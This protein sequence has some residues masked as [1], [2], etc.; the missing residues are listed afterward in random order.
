MSE[1]K[2][3]ALTSARRRRGV[4]KGSITRLEDRV[5][6]YETKEEITHVDCLAIKRLIKKFES[7]DD[8]FRK[9]HY[10]IVELLEDEAVDEEQA[11]LDDHD[12]RITDLVER[13]Q[14]LIIIPEPEVDSPTSAITDASKPLQVQLGRIEK[15]IG[16]V[17]ETMTSLIRGPKIDQCLLRQLEEEI[18]SLRAELTE[19][20][21][22]IT[23]LETGGKEL[24]EFEAALNKNLFDLGLRIKR[25]LSDAAS[26]KE[27][28]KV[29]SGVKL[30]KIE[31]P[32]F[33]GNI[34]NWGH[35]WEQFTATVHAKE[36]LSDVDKLAYLQHA[37]K[38]GTAKYTIEGLAQSSGSYKEA[39]DCLQ[40]RYDRPR[41]IH[42]AHVRAI[43]DA[44]P[45]KDGHGREL[46]RMHDV[47]NQHL[48]A[49]KTMDYDPSGPFIT[50][51]LELK[52]D[53]STMFEWQRHSQDSRDVPHYQRL[54]EFLDLRA[55]ASESNPNTTRGGKPQQKN[56]YIANAGE[57]CIACEAGK[58]P[59]YTCGTFRTMD[60][61][62]KL[63]LLKENGHCLN[64]LKPG[65]FLRQCPT[66]Q[67]CRK[68][69]KPHHT[70]LHIEKDAGA[71]KVKGPTTTKAISSHASHLET[72]HQQVLLMTCRVKIVA[73]GGY[74]TQA[75]ALLDSASSTSFITERLA[76]HLGLRR[77]RHSL[78]ISG[79]GGI[80]ARSAARGIVSFEITNSQ[81]TCKVIP[82]EAIV[83]QRITTDIPTQPI[84]RDRGWKHLNGLHLADPDFGK[85]GRIDL[86]LGADVFGKS[87]RHGRRYGPAGTPT[88]LSTQFG[89]VITGG[90]RTKCPSGKVSTFCASALSGDDLLKRFWEVEG[91]TFPNPTFSTEERNVMEHFKRN[92]S[93]DETGRFVVPLPRRPD[94]T[95]LGES[96]LI[97]VKRFIAVERSLESS[98]RSRDFANAVWEYFDMDHAEPVPTRDMAKPL[99]E[100]YYMPMHTVI[101]TSSVTSQMR[102]VFDA[103]AKTAS[104]TSLN[105]HLIV[106]PTVHASLV[107]VLL[108]FRRHKIALVADISKMYRAV[109]LPEN[110]RDLH[111]FVWRN[112]PRDP[113]VD[114]RMKRLTF[115]VSASSF[116]AN[117]AVKQNAIDHAEKYPQASRAVLESFYVDDGLTGADTLADAVELQGQLQCLFDIAGFTLRKWKSNLPAVLKQ[118]PPDLRDQ[119]PC[120]EIGEVSEFTKVLGVE[121]D[122]E[123]D[124][125]RPLITTNLIAC[126]RLTKRTLVSDIAR[127]FDVLGWCSPSIIKLKIL[128]QRIWEEK[129]EWDEE[130]P[131]NVSGI[132]ERWRNELPLLRNHLIPRCYFQETTFASRQLHGFCDAS[133]SAYAAVVYLRMTDLKGDAKVAIVIGKTKVAPI[134][135]LTI[136]RLELCGALILARILKHAADILNVPMIDVH[137]WT[138]STVVL[139]WLRG[140]PRRFKS[141]VG[142]RV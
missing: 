4:V 103:S 13:L 88:A 80:E 85:P 73:P 61:D 40:K 110:Q 81:G 48:R 119:Q 86:L 33:D 98:G 142:N 129:L 104:G 84:P 108:R 47:V 75:R 121:W 94:V 32:T 12:E 127:V 15:R 109:L 54:L 66:D 93:R 42:Q 23:L 133:E 55:Q 118:V 77:T 18:L 44:A 100:V 70:W 123:S 92:H 43:I 68:C 30:P 24:L 79:I 140:N 134:K 96:R 17:N 67:H 45:L 126:E 139:S 62:K 128:L 99:D 89:W 27:T 72:C 137:A 59:L 34:L 71:S 82:V 131:T 101:K 52:L 51:L 50:S 64:C 106:G 41:L 83:M 65:H 35:F 20:G 19:T 91:C 114:Y 60:H 122:G 135:R 141:F 115:G 120:L 63:S 38:D 7:L 132:W 1:E 39:I 29:H 125:F 26:E 2:R 74:T 105:D 10:T 76:Q 53:Q 31:V 57:L 130:V 8:E 36:Q 87:I 25:L 16:M 136:P 14:Q 111:R 102:V 11:T 9:H 116:A 56:T 6:K 78:T 49:L 58:H 138:D 95:P 97:A 124:S 90:V 28:S 112:S 113:F 22:A 107:N 117:M 3:V 69:Q 46:R 21:R 5:D 37:L